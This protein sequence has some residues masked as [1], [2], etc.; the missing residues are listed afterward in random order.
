MQIAV[1][2]CSMTLQG[3]KTSGKNV[4]EVMMAAQRQLCQNPMPDTITDPK[5]SKQRLFNDVI[6]FLTERG[7]KWWNS[8]VSSASMNLATALTDTLWTTHDQF[9]N[10]YARQIRCYKPIEKLYCTQI[11]ACNIPVGMEGLLRSWIG[12][13]SQFTDAPWINK[14]TKQCEHARGNGVKG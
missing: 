3:T 1:I 4:F 5:N 8:D 10:V 13:I 2:S 7:C 14:Q 6:S 11:G 12:L 9:T